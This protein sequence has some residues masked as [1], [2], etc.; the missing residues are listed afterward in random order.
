MEVTERNLGP[1]S[2]VHQSDQ[3]RAIKH[4]VFW[5]RTLS[6][7][8]LR[9]STGLQFVSQLPCASQKLNG[10]PRSGFHFPQLDS[11]GLA[12]EVTAE[13]WMA[14]VVCGDS[15]RN[16]NGKD[17]EANRGHGKRKEWKRNEKQTEIE[18]S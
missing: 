2:T 12:Q 18:W 15:N 10:L 9:M 16:K 8:L 13:A 6:I 14:K 17:M 1:I 3:S 7:H 11:S 5:G 4:D